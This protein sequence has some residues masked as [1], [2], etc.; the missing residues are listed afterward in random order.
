M[1]ETEDV[2]FFGTPKRR[3][4][5]EIEIVAR[6][7]GKPMTDKTDDCTC[8]LF[9]ACL[10]PTCNTCEDMLKGETE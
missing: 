7:K 1:V 4:P 2:V 10:C 3:R 8:E 5:V 9:P 6:R